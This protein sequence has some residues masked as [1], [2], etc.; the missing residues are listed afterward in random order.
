VRYKDD[1]QYRLICSMTD[2]DIHVDGD[3]IISNLYEDRLLKPYG[4][5]V[6]KE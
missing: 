1:E 5:V 6:S 2:K 4:F 3:I